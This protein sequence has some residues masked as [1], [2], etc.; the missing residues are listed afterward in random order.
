MSASPRGWEIRDAQEHDLGGVLALW[1]GAGSVRTPTDDEQSLRT[2]L[3]FDPEAVI[4]AELQGALVGSVIVG[5]D[6]WRGSF[7]RLAVRPPER[8]HGLA[9][10]LVRE[11]ERRLQ[12]RAAVRLNAI[13]VADERGAVRFWGAVG[14]AAHPEQLRFVRDLGDRAQDP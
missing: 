7:Y 2:L 12:R 8:R 11:G 6:G 9:T 5:W 14:Y 1:E 13:V 4:V 10:E 3:A